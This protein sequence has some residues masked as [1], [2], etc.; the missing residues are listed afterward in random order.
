M[1]KNDDLCWA[2]WGLPIMCTIQK[3]NIS[4]FQQ[5]IQVLEHWHGENTTQNFHLCAGFASASGRTGSSLL[6]ETV[7]E[8]SH[9]LVFPSFWS[10]TA[11]TSP[12]AV[13]SVEQSW[14]KP[15]SRPQL[16]KGLPQRAQPFLRA[17]FN[18]VILWQ[19]SQKLL[20]A[21]VG[22]E[23]WPKELLP[24]W[25]RRYD[26]VE[27]MEIRFFWGRNHNLCCILITLRLLY[28]EELGGA[29]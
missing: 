6:P 9:I 13:A 23:V 21:Q 25:E 11:Q 28:L 7:L 10:F 14:G 20:Q 5:L 12:L 4:P 18:G 16:S 15:G 1:Y 22:R 29:G 26:K 8:S 3:F 24:N 27:I 2:L 17:E 19:F